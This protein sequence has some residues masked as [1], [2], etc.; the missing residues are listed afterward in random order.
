MDAALP[1]VFVYGTL[2]K[3]DRVDAILDDWR[4]DGAAVLEGL[5]RVEGRYPTLAP[6][7][8]TEG[9]LLVTPELDALDAYERIDTGLYVRIDVPLVDGDRCWIYVGDPDRL[10]APVDWPGEGPFADRV[11]RCIET[12][13]VRVR[14]TGNR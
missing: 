12:E 1:S 3:P 9:R 5:Q 11:R 6:G 13:T 2:T 10:D 8:R 14:R 4:F 7:G